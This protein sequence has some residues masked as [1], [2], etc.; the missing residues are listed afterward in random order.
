MQE[1]KPVVSLFAVTEQEE[2][3]FANSKMIAPWNAVT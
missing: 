3:S 1:N 2:N